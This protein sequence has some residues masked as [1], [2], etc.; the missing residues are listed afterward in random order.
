MSRHDLLPQKAIDQC[1]NPAIADRAKVL[2]GVRII[3]RRRHQPGILAAIPDRPCNRKKRAAAVRQNHQQLG[4]ASPCQA[5]DDGK[6]APFKGMP[7][8]CDDGR[9]LNVLVMGSL[10]WLRSIRSR[11]TG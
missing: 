3:A 4:N 6:S 2:G 7:F 10:S 1:Q 8:A 11:M 5:L 9:N